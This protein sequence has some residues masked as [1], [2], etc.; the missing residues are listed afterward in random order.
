MYIA[1]SAFAMYIS[2]EELVSPFYIIINPLLIYYY[3]AQQLRLLG[4]DFQD[5]PYIQN[6]IHSLIEATSRT[7]YLEICHRLQESK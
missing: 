1:V 5:N 7:A 2:K 6:Q 4:G 3:K